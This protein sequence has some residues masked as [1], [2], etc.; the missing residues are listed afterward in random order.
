MMLHNPGVG[1][2]GFFNKADLERIIASLTA[3]ESSIIRCYSERI[4]PEKTR[5]LL[6]RET[7]L[8]AQE[9]KEIGLVDEI[10]EPI[11]DVT[12]MLTGG[13]KM[14]SEQY[15]SKARREVRNQEMERIRELQG[16]MG[17][18][19][20]VNALIGTAIAQGHTAA[21]I[22][23]YLDALTLPQKKEATAQI[24]AMIRDQLTSGAQNVTGGQEPPDIKAANRQKLINFANGVA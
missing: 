19:S 24:E 6:D 14:T 1:L 18:N 4:T 10:M 5:E 15:L 17:T 13:V 12:G 23:P 16:L 11:L 8:S 9:A 22:K 3:S 7:W 20:N 21:E 2:F